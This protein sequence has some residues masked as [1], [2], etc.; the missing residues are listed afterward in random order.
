MAHFVVI[1][2]NLRV[3]IDENK[4]LFHESRPKFEAGICEELAVL[5]T[6]GK[7]PSVFVAV[8][9]YTMILIKNVCKSYLLIDMPLRNMLIFQRIYYFLALLW[10]STWNDS[11]GNSL[12]HGAFI[13]NYS[14][15]NHN[16]LSDFAF[17][18][19]Q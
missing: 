1:S 12:N 4:I 14:C 8:F 19:T 2:R 13:R 17:I 9:E 10:L 7:R 3:G 6:T 5:L 18:I 16:I 11:Q 15:Q